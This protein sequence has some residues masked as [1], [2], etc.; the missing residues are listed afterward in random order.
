VARG[1]SR[2]ATAHITLDR[3]LC[4]ACWECIDACPNDVLGRIKIGP[5]RHAVVRSPEEC[6]GCLACVKR[7]T[8][9][10]L[11]VLVEPG[12]DQDIV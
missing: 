3:G 8:S 12:G 5:H 6:T 11:T 9:G 10:A 4:D 7:C 1:R 2:T